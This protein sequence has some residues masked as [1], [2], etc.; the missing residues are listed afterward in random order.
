VVAGAADAPSLTI[1]GTTTAQSGQ[2]YRVR[3][4]NGA[5]SVISNSALLTVTSAPAAP[6]FT[7]QPAAQTIAAGQVASFTVAATGTPAPIISGASA[8]ATLP[9]AHRRAACAPA[10]ACPAPSAPR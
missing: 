1:S 9:M 4:S 7:T 6:T 5:G 2:R 3:V 8:A 10:P